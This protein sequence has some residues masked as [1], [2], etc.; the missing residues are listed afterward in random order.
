M[1]SGFSLRGAT[2]V[3]TIVPPLSLP[4]KTPWIPGSDLRDEEENITRSAS[5]ATSS[6]RVFA[7]SVTCR[8]PLQWPGRY[9]ASVTPQ[10]NSWPWATPQDWEYPGLRF[11]DHSL[12]VMV[13]EIGPAGKV[14]AQVTR[15]ACRLHLGL[16]MTDDV[17]N[18]H[19]ALAFH[20][21]TAARLTHK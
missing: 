20:G 17:E 19:L 7:R 1:G 2:T 11:R 12:G 18:G 21:H 9:A 13:A 8:K 10:T 16:P 5:V 6:I 3:T 4:R 14:G 15:G